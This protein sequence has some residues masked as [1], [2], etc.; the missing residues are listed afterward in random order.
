VG[1]RS[2]ECELGNGCLFLSLA[3]VAGIDNRLPWA[4]CAVLP[5]DMIDDGDER[6]VETTVF[7]VAIEAESCDCHDKPCLLTRTA[8]QEPTS[9]MFLR[10]GALVSCRRSLAT[11]KRLLPPLRYLGNLSLKPASGIDPPAERHLPEHAVISTF[12]LFSIGG[13]SKSSR[14]SHRLLTPHR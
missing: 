3:G 14:S 8:S 2:G 5:E 12:D 9:S 4:P 13:T 1:W 11:P 6:K 10:F 7:G